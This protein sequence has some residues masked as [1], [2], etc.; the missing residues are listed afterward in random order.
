MDRLPSVT[1][2]LSPHSDFSN[3]P[4][5]ILGAAQER[6]DAIHQ[7]CALYAQG[8]FIEEVPEQYAGYFQSFCLW[9]DQFVE[10]TVLVEEEL[11]DEDRGYI[12]HPDFIGRLKGDSGLILVDWKTARALSK[13]WRLQ[14]AGYKLL[15]EK[16]GYPI[17]RV[18]SLRPQKDGKIAKFQGYTRSL[19]YDASIFLAELS[20]WRFYDAA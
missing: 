19:A 13:G 8:L 4:A 14:V 16:N 5:D 12:G 2:V 7:L 9:F 11:R 1:E 10:K 20:V 6:G 15:A 18:A 17:S 3:V